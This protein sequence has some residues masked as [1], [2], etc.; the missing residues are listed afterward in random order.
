M[1]WEH[2]LVATV[3]YGLGYTNVETATFGECVMHAIIFGLGWLTMEIV[4]HMIRE[5]SQ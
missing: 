5:A 1:K 4:W 2:V 3:G